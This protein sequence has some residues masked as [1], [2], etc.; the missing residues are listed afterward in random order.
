MTERER[1]E[2]E[3]LVRGLAKATVASEKAA[4]LSLKAYDRLSDL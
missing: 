2:R 1:V 3:T 4:L